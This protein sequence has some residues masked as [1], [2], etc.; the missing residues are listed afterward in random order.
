MSTISLLFDIVK[1]YII[2]DNIIVKSGIT[3]IDKSSFLIYPEGR[4][5]R[6]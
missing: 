5:R 4:R 2:E 1:S 6:L 3:A